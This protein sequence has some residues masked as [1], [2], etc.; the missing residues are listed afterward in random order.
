MTGTCG[1]CALWMR[2]AAWRDNWGLCTWK[3]PR[4]SSAW[5]IRGT[6]AQDGTQ[7]PMFVPHEAN[8]APGREGT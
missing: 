3:A 6:R 5:G 2:P 1:S 7:C 8:T 4:L